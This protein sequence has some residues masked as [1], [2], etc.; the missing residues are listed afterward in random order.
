MHV[1]AIAR[2]PGL[3]LAAVLCG[4]DASAGAAAA[5]LPG[6]AVHRDL[7]ALLRDRTIDLVDIVAPNHLHAGMAI[8]ALEAG[9]HVLLEKPMAT[10]LADAE[11]LVAAAE[12]SG[13]YIGIGLELHVS[14]QW[15]RVRELIAEGTLG[16]L[17]YANLT[18]FRRPFRGGSGGW[19]HT[20]ERVGSWILEE[21]IHYIDLLLWYF[22]ERGLPVEVS[23]DGVPSARGAGMYDAFTCTLR[24]ADGAYAVF[25]Q[26]LG[27]FEHSL[28]LEIAGDG[29][30]L[31]TWWS[32]AMDRTLEP[33][34]ELKLQRAGAAEAEVVTIE[35]SGEVF[36]LEEQ[37]RR[38]VEDVPRRTPLVS[39]RDALPSLKICF[40][41]E[42]ALS[43]RRP[44]K[45]AWT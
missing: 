7:D 24:F 32:G 23:A 30:A 9:K 8:K 15:A 38:L 11:R 1:G 4:S 27:G 44:I 20:S 34:F 39:P 37:F 13:R 5:E 35:K 21:P 42:R 10:T 28:I 33:D 40:E 6:I 41:I 16:R 31:R 26:C 36:E 12:R 2:I 45:L 18:L 14:K 22:R 25:S 29:G 17:R 43:E 19:R 3:S